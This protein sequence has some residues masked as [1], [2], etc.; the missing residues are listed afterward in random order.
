LLFCLSPS[1]DRLQE[2]AIASGASNR[3]ARV[4]R[5][6]VE[7]PSLPVCPTPTG[8]DPAGLDQANFCREGH[9][10]SGLY[11]I[12]TNPRMIMIARRTLALSSLFGGLS[13]SLKN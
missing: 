8:F 9:R 12:A 13:A 6:N 5:T 1:Q 4:K 7:P 2:P 11:N 10:R 3:T